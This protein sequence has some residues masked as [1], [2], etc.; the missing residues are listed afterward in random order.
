M[1]AAEREQLAKVQKRLDSG[2]LVDQKCWSFIKELN[3]YSEERL[4]SVA[5]HDGYRKYTY[6]QMFRY[7]EL[8]AEA[9]TGAHLTGKDHARVALIGAQ[10][11]E[12]IFAFYALNMTGASVSLIYHLDLYDE[13][14]IRTMIEREKITDLVISEVYAFPKIMKKLLREKEVLGL[15]NIVLLE[16]PM[17]GEY[18]IPPLEGIRKLNAAAFRELEGGL[19]M[20]DLLKEY[21]AAPIAYGSNKSSDGSIIMH[22]TG[23][24]SGIHKPIPMSD[25]ALNSFVVCAMEAKDTYP[26]FKKAPKKMVSFLAL[27]LSWVYSMVDMLH[28]PFGLGMEV[29]CLPLGATNPHYANA[30]EE[31]GISI[32]FTSMS[33]LDTWNKTMPD[34]NLSKVKLVFMGGTYVSPE[35]KK[36]FNDYLRSCGSTARII[37]G[38]G[39]SEMGGACIV[40]SSEREDDA[41]GY[42]LP[43]FKVKIFSEDEK[44]F[45]DLSDGPRTGVLY[46]SS[47]TMSSGRLD[48]TVFFELEE[49]DGEEYFNSNDLVRV[50]EDGSMTCIG[51]SNKFFV[52]NAG[53]RFDAGLIETAITAQ[54]GIVACGVVPEHHK[55]LHDNVPIL[56]VETTG[57]TSGLGVV[58]D[59]LIQVFI[60]DGK[61]AETNLPSQCVLVEKIPLNSGGKVDAK[62]LQSGAVTG[63]RFSIKHVK[64]NDRIN[65]I[66]LLPA[67]E[68]EAATVSGGIPEELEN[69][70]YNILSE[71][72]AA[73]PEIKENG[74]ASVLNI[75]GFREI[76]KKLTDFDIDNIPGSITKIAPKLMKLSIDELPPMP[77]MSG[78]G[79]KSDTKNWLKDLVSMF[80]DMEIPEFPMPI[81]PPLPVIPPLPLMPPMLPMA[82][83]GFWGK[84]S[85]KD[86]NKD[87]SCGASSRDFMETMNE[88]TE[89]ANKYAREQ[90]DLFFNFFLPG[91]KKTKETTSKTVKRTGKEASDNAADDEE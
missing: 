57:D 56:Y 55:V 15:R 69:D 83:W 73:I 7:W 3:S 86:E 32:L 88:F 22:T 63:K 71:I 90:A 58:R 29:V 54:P 25:R 43:G 46:L 74:I 87:K 5:V 27:C 14:R 9:F 11:T 53:V 8:Y 10:Q 33:I 18:P 68:G 59:A 81:V 28:T 79:R 12:T 37:N 30:I 24:V 35:F 60:K 50:N 1:K 75:P 65:D 17:G 13:K 85:S 31:C 67:T 47:P 77:K 26:D 19:L 38:Y 40:A 6:R 49:I 84:K 91:Q 2:E 70:P 62:R 16:S 51:R 52:N 82:P 34:I 42:P 23:T 39:L 45:Y 44:K 89:N 80:E 66:L 61:L 78:G 20:D 72:F 4:D 41:I 76:V 48:D 64:L 36:N 21:E